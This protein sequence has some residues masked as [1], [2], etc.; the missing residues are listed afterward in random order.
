MANAPIMSSIIT[1]IKNEQLDAEIDLNSSTI[2][3]E[4]D[5]VIAVTAK[6]IPARLAFGA[7]FALPCLYFLNHVISNLEL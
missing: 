7:L 4:H 3:Q 5:G 1:R 6:L 2:K